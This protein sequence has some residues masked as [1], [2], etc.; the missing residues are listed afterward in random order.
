MPI[1]QPEATSAPTNR[2]TF[3][4]RAAF[5]GALVGVG[6]AA[7][8]FGLFAPAAGAQDAP[9][10]T[11]EGSAPITNATFAAFA[12]PLEM[13]AVLAYQ[14]VL[15]SERLDGAWADLA[16]D[17]QGHHQTVV[18]A[19][20]AQLEEGLADPEAN[21]VLL[22]EVTAAIDGAG[23]Q[24]AVLLSLSE[25]EDTIAATHLYCLGGLDDPSLAKVV[26]QVLAVESQQAATMGLAGGV[27]TEEL[28]PSAA[29]TESARTN[30]SEGAVSAPPPTTTTTAATEGTTT[31]EA[32]N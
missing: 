29:G 27:A 6:A 17:F 22:D 13:A 15:G 10:A 11:V 12:V 24:E 1:D 32:G 28:T 20:T 21:P 31:T 8:P 30:L 7:G 18:D 26:A 25:L 14:Q 16:L 3:L 23:S 19:L 9:L 4:T 5:G 2:R